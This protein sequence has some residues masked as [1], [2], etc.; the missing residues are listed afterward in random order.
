MLTWPSAAHDTMVASFEPG[1]ARAW[2]TLLR[3]PLL[4]FS[5]C[6]PERATR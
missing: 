5:F 1:N 2:N 4:Y 3:C 6:F